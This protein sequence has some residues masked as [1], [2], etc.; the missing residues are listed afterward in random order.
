MWK[1]VLPVVVL[2]ILG[3]F[4]FRGLSLNPRLIESPLIGKPA[5]AFALPNLENPSVEVSSQEF[6]GQYSILNVWATW[7]VECRREHPFLLELADSGVPIYGLNWNDDPDAA[8]AWLATLGDPYAAT[9]LDQHGVVGIDY[10][11]YGAPETFLIGPDQ[12]VLAKY[13][14]PLDREIWEAVFVP[15]IEKGHG[16]H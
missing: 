1:Y 14:S 3:V 10:G 11:V 6:A 16:E 13:I 4:F 5:P 8:R 2:A 12:T 7:C 15:L 9:A